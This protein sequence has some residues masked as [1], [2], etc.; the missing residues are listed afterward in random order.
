MTCGVSPV[1]VTDP[2]IQGIKLSLDCPI[3]KKKKPSGL[4]VG[5]YVVQI[6]AHI[7]MVFTPCSGG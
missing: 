3:K 7:G 4:S 6:V 1:T 2:P 5:T